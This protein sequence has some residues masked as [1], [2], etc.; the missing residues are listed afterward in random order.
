M[1]FPNMEG[2]LP[3]PGGARRY[4]GRVTLPENVSYGRTLAVTER[5]LP[6]QGEVC[7]YGGTFAVTEGYL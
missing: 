3:L 7:R 1:G 6:L 2:R 4:N 5:R